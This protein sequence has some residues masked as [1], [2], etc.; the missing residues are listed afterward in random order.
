MENISTIV[1]IA[2]KD[3]LRGIFVLLFLRLWLAS[4]QRYAEKL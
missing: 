2:S 4:N 3:L 1:H